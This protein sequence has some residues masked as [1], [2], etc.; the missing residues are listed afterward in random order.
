MT[1]APRTLGFYEVALEVSDL[2]AAERFY[3]DGLG[4]EEIDR[5]GDPRPAF[6]VRLGREG[7]LGLW[8][9]D[10]G[11][12]K[13]LFGG[14]GGEHVHLAIRVRP[15]DLAAMKEHLA[16]VGIPL[17][18]ETTFGNGNTALYVRDQ[19]DHLIEITEIYTLWDGSPAV[20]ID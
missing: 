11:G 6:W 7:F 16:A 4:L 14:R 18:G 9:Q 19:D 20:N 1:Q 13:A 12:E 17:A 2:A 15:G 5:W 10:A 8:T 3:C